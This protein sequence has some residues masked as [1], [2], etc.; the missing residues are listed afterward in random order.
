M[1]IGVITDIHG[2]VPALKAVLNELDKRRDI[3]HIY[4]LGDMI[5]IGPD[6]N[7]VLEI[8]FARNDVSMVTG[9]H[10]EAV[11]ALLKGE[12]HPLSHLQAKEHHQWIAKNMD[13]SF[14]SSLERLPRYI[15]KTIEG[16]RI[17][18]THYH[19]DKTKIKTHISQDPFSPI[20]EPS[21]NNMKELFRGHSE[22]L[23]CFGHHHPLHYFKNNHTIFLNPGSLGCQPKPLAPYS[24]VELTKENIMVTLEQVAYDN[25]K[26]L[27]SYERL[28]VPA[29]EF[30]IKVFHGN[31]LS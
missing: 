15:Q 18:F 14:I 25:R 3:E 17:L 30:I 26:F 13:K 19:I 31:Q 7:E 16:K 22:D 12:E 27:E 8:L 9:N 6:T 21:L 4:C 10:D 5:G 28:K 11:L 1:K 2:N 20:V 23:I 24:V 29:R